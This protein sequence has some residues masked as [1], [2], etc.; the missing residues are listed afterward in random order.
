MAHTSSLHLED[1]T[2]P[3]D[4]VLGRAMLSQAMSV[5]PHT[6][7]QLHGQLMAAQ[8]RRV[9]SELVQRL[10]Q[11]PPGQIVQLGSKWV[12]EHIASLHQER[13][14]SPIAIERVLYHLCKP[15]NMTSRKAIGVAA[16][17]LR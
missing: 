2:P 13:D 7:L 11:S 4:G 15:G 14:E 10:Q 3:V 9:Q 8:P 12:T 6:V 16:T 17:H 1:K 5:P